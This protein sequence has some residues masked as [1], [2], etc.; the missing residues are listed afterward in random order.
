ML[1]V[2][3]MGNAEQ[4]NVFVMMGLLV[5]NVTKKVVQT[6]AANTV[7]VMT[8]LVF[9]NAMLVLQTRIARGNCDAQMQMKH[10]CV[11]DAG[12]ATKI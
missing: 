5:S 12:N 2:V 7:N 6:I 4:K 3:A 8:K 10:L 1:H 11:T 9:V